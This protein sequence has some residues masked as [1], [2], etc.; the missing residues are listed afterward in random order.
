MLSFRLLTL[1]ALVPLTNYK[2]V[3]CPTVLDAA[4]CDAHKYIAS[5]VTAVPVSWGAHT[6]V[7][8]DIAVTAVTT[9]PMVQVF[10]QDA[11]FALS[12]SCNGVLNQP[13]GMHGGFPA[14]LT[15]PTLVRDPIQRARRYALPSRPRSRFPPPSP[16]KSLGHSSVRVRLSSL[17]WM[18]PASIMALRPHRIG[19]WGWSVFGQ[20][21]SNS[22]EPAPVVR[23][24]PPPNTCTL[25]DL[26][27]CGVGALYFELI[28]VLPEYRPTYSP[29]PEL[30]LIGF[31]VVVLVV[32]GL[33][34]TGVLSL[35]WWM[36]HC[37]FYALIAVV[38]T[39]VKIVSALLCILGRAA[40]CLLI[41]VAAL[42]RYLCSLWGAAIPASNMQHGEQ[43]YNEIVSGA[44]LARPSWTSDRS[45][46][47]DGR[48][49]RASTVD[50]SA[51]GRGAK[52]MPAPLAP[53]AGP[54]L[55]SD[56]VAATSI[57][58]D[59]DELCSFT[60]A[61]S[62]GPASVCSSRST[63]V[64]ARRSPKPSMARN[65]AVGRARAKRSRMPR[66]EDYQADHELSDREDKRGN[67][68]AV[69]ASEPNAEP[70]GLEAP[71]TGSGPL[72]QPLSEAEFTL[73][74]WALFGAMFVEDADTGSL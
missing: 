43:C 64:H 23:S 16:I 47:L 61:T 68:V 3:I 60:D 46:S 1:F 20:R 48:D 41:G 33:V 2:S 56:S 42:W 29:L 63:R 69:G 53:D 11:G 26:S 38:L 17:L 51:Q 71:S 49:P 74:G 27:R 73:F 50:V 40:G 67:E 31:M 57:A 52:R 7:E 72:H 65:R 19:L 13:Y 8:D 54:E 10:T 25:P 30:L 5:A 32:A 24:G 66:D 62:I 6:V 36:I 12:D 37:V 39:A 35:V 9:A 14:M 18:D 70:L 58:T 59:S 44:V 28:E 15:N 21:H 34:Y 55:A 22:D 45:T 4:L